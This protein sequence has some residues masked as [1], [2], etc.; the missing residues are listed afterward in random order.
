M[1]VRSSS[2]STIWHASGGLLA[3][4]AFA[5]AGGVWQHPL[6]NDGVLLTAQ[7]EARRSFDL[8]LAMQT[9]MGLY[10]GGAPTRAALDDM[11]QVRFWHPWMMW[12]GPA[13]IGSTRGLGNYE[14]YHQIPFLVAFPDRGKLQGKGY[15]GHFIRIGDGNYAV[16]G[17]W[18]HLLARTAASTGWASR[19][20]AR[21]STCA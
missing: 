13:G 8:M 15:S 18:G 16:T 5:G 14:Q 19:P 9:A 1:I 4:G 21:S 11:V 17:G 20:R 12:Y 3:A 7:D 6:T 10:R 2:T